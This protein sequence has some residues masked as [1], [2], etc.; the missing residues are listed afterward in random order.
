EAW[1]PLNSFLHNQIEPF[2]P[3]GSPGELASGGGHGDLFRAYRVFLL[4]GPRIAL[5]GSCQKSL[6]RR[7]PEKRRR[8]GTRRSR[9]W[10]RCRGDQRA[11]SPFFLSVITIIF[12]AIGSNG[13]YIPI[14]TSCLP[15][16]PSPHPLLLGTLGQVGATNK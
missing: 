12:V 6:P 8:A 15:Q 4:V 1:A 16:I 9:R 11:S 13:G 3:S 7:T 2:A 5:V 14:F 10:A